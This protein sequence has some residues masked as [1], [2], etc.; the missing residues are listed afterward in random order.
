MKDIL[1]DI[2]LGDLLAI[3]TMAGI[4]FAAGVGAGIAW[5]GRH[6]ERESAPVRSVIH[7]I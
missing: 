6:D 5:R 2:T 1:I 3:A 4:T 7:R